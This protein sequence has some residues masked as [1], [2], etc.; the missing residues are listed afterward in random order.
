MKF[1]ETLAHAIYSE[2]VYARDQFRW[3][4]NSHTAHRALELVDT[5]ARSCTTWRKTRV[6]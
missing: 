1:D 4:A 3:A 2:S 6:S 5:R